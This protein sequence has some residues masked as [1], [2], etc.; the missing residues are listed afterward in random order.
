[1]E[2]VRYET[3]LCSLLKD[4]ICLPWFFSL[5]DTFLRLLFTL[6]C[7]YYL[8]QKKMMDLY[9]VKYKVYCRKSVFPRA[10]KMLQYLYIEL[11]LHNLIPQR[12]TFSYLNEYFLRN[13]TVLYYVFIQLTFTVSCILMG[14]FPRR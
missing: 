14:Y 4:L 3:K 7:Y 1:M 6:F 8:L 9:Y 10:K 13:K 5:Q 2:K 11:K 12:V